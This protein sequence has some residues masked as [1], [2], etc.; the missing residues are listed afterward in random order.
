MKGRDKQGF[1]E[2]FA[3][4]W[5]VFILFIAVFKNGIFIGIGLHNPN[6][7][8]FESSVLLTLITT[9]FVAV[10]ILAQIGNQ[11]FKW[12]RS[13]LKIGAAA[14]LI[15]L[16]YLISSAQAFSPYMAKYGILVHL[17]MFLFFAAGTF[18]SRSSSLTRQ[19]PFVFLIFGYIIVFFGF[20]TMFGNAYL[21]DSLTSQDG[22]RITS[23]FQ[24]ANAYAVLLLIMWIV[25]LIE[26]NRTSRRGIQLLHGIMLVPVCV[27]FLLTLSRG[28]LIVL[29]FIA[30]I[31]L[32]MLRLKLQ[33]KLIVYSMLGMGISLLIYSKLTDR[34][35]EVIGGIQAAGDAG[36]K[37]NTVSIFSGASI[38]YWGIL[39]AASLVMGLFTYAIERFIEPKLNSRIER[40]ST[41][42]ANLWLPIGLVVLFVAGAIALIS[43]TVTQLLP[44]VLRK[45]IEGVNFET[46]SVYERLTM[47]K[48]AIRLWKEYPIFGGGGGAWEAS[49][50]KYQSYPYLSAQTH[51]FVTQLL[52]EVGIVGAVAVIGL[53]VYVLVNFIITYR[54]MDDSERNNAIFYFIVPVAILLHATIDFEMSY[55]LYDI[56]VFLCLGVLAS[57]RSSLVVLTDRRRVLSRRIA[58]SAMSA[59]GLALLLI[60]S[61]RFYSVRQIDEANQ[62]YAT[63][64]PFAQIVDPLKSGL[65]L[66]AG[67]PVLLL[68]LASWNY[69]AY[70]QSK[71]ENYLQQSEKYLRKL[72]DKEPYYRPAINLEFTIQRVRGNQDA[73][74][75][76]MKRAVE[77]Y[78]FEQSF[79]EQLEVNLLNRWNQERQANDAER[80]KAD[81]QLI[82]T[83]YDQAVQ[84]VKT[85]EELPETIE[86]ARTFV[87]SNRLRAAAGEVSFAE[88]NY[89]ETLDMLKPGLQ[90]DLSKEEDRTVARIYLAALRKQGQDDPAVYDRLVA[91]DADE[92]ERLESLK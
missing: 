7:Y 24:Y 72:V 5:L 65:S 77:Q 6:Q 73:A 18:W 67:H 22:I 42:Y 30:I 51:S 68:Q 29:P 63:Q 31:T 1:R 2:W 66:S 46:H 28:A 79:Y 60:G 84:Q 39:V 25:M 27:S 52:V 86:L 87:I 61:L 36:Q 12:T 40:L 70:D 80:A 14:L 85:T 43:D 50:E 56:L 90:E 64:R 83:Y 54:R 37:F 23:V 71:D 89:S 81:A 88:G 41:S 74:I 33:I 21:L 62:A 10:W 58:I 69:Q 92:A 32:A 75:E 35:I 91:V 9:A 26:I 59:I 82:R 13:N 20:L 11:E 44:P 47:Y 78:P 57:T 15:P 4:T 3:W 19:L 49:Y 16:V 34:G 53:I 48:D 8:Q 38:G 17:A 76:V 55:L 45:R